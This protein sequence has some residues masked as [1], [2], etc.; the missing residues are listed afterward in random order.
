MTESLIIHQP[1]VFVS[2][3]IVFANSQQIAAHFEKRHDH[4]LRDIDG[5][6]NSGESPLDFFHLTSYVDGQNGQVYRSYNMTRDGIM[7][8]CMGFTGQRALQFKLD[9]IKAFN[10]VEAT[11]KQQHVKKLAPVRMSGALMRELRL[12][13]DTLPNALQ[14][15]PASK[16]AFAAALYAPLGIELAAPPVERT[17]STTE[18]AKQYSMALT[19][20]GKRVNHLKTVDR[21]ELRLNTAPNGKQVSVWVRNEVG[22]NAIQ[23]HFAS[24]LI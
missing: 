13:M 22:R 5:L 21:G 19:T 4:V 2:D 8:L 20:F 16:Q 1:L 6:L 14:L 11:I 3:G 15:S 17:Y 10:D 24:S 9:F 7:L 12:A 18:L 23:H